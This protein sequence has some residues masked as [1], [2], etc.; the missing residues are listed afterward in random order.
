M[1]NTA[2]GWHD[3]DREPS[4]NVH[5]SPRASDVP[6]GMALTIAQASGDKTQ[7]VGRKIPLSDAELRR[8]APSVEPPPRR[9]G[10]GIVL[11]L[12]LAVAATI[13][14]AGVWYYYLRPGGS[15]TPE[16]AFLGMI[17]AFNNADA[18]AAISHTTVN[19]AEE[20]ERDFEI[21]SLR[22]FWQNE[23]L[24]TVTVES[25]TVVNRH[26]MGPSVI[27]GLDEMVQWI[28]GKYQVDVEDSCAIEFTVTTIKG[29]DS[30]TQ[31]GVVPVVKIDSGWYVALMPFLDGEFVV[32][33]VW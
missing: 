33:P 19:F 31:D 13:V 8:L 28:E 18:E 7:R 2:P 24:F 10:K 5:L 15:R 16:A 23:G 11:V 1:W 9:K 17:D 21:A 30:Y 29:V 12:V 26:M 4:N 25:L 32:E 14:L 22:M 3:C 6:E 27:E 20:T